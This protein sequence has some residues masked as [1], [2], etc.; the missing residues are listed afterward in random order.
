[1]SNVDVDKN[2]LDMFLSRQETRPNNYILVA[3][4]NAV[5]N[6]H[7]PSDFHALTKHIR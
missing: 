3:F 2:G 1:M 7:E 6:N 5:G 4:Q